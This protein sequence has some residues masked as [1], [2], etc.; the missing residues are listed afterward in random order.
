MGCIG[1]DYK[2]KMDES[3]RKEEER[4]RDNGYKYLSI[5]N[6]SHGDEFFSFLFNKDWKDKSMVGITRDKLYSLCSAKI[7]RERYVHF[8][9]CDDMF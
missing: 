9:K 1:E 3:I 7:S 4:M 6:P 2:K 8:S 5:A